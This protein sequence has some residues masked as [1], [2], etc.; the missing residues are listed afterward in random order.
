MLFPE[1]PSIFYL[2]QTVM[3]WIW[4]CR[5]GQLAGL[6]ASRDLLTS[7]SHLAFSGITGHGTPGF[8]HGLKGSNLRSSCFP[9]KHITN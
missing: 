8:L 5:P 9:G 4:Q 3:S 1:A 2:R 6:Q 7:A